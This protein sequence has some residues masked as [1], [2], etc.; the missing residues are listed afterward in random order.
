MQSS[1]GLLIAGGVLALYV[2]IGPLIL[3]AIYT[4]FDR[5]SQKK[6]SGRVQAS[7]FKD[8]DPALWTKSDAKGFVR[9]QKAERESSG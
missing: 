5:L 9:E 6:E 2:I 4:L 1:P 8:K 3:L 7:S